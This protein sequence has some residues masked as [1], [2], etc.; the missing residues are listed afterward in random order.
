RPPTRAKSAEPRATPKLEA[1]PAPCL[2]LSARRS[3]HLVNAAIVSVRRRAEVNARAVGPARKR[4]LAEMGRNELIGEIVAPSAAPSHDILDGDEDPAVAALATASPARAAV[5]RARVFVERHTRGIVT[6]QE[7]LRRPKWARR[8]GGIGASN[9][10]RRDLRR[11]PV[12]ARH[13]RT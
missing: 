3:A 9:P 5:E 12:R 4:E 8:V 6:S 2:E 13:A 11:R 10:V 7:A 1:L